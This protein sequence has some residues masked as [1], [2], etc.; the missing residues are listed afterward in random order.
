MS[1]DELVRELSRANEE[2][3]QAEKALKAALADANER[4]A[5]LEEALPVEQDGVWVITQ[6][7]HADDDD[8][9]AVLE[10]GTTMEQAVTVVVHLNKRNAAVNTLDSRTFFG[11]RWVATESVADVL[12]KE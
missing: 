11:A 8:I 2:L 4:V 3:H 9:Y 6:C 1:I 10:R 12:A 7:S 5:M